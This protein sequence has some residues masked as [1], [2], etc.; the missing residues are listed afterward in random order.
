MKM[1]II[2]MMMLISTSISFLKTPMSMGVMLLMQTMLST[3]ILAKMMSSSWMSMIIFLMLIGGLLILF[4]YMSSIAS[5]EKFK[6]NISM[7][8]MLLSIA[9]PLEEMM[10][11]IQLNDTQENLMGI[12]TF[13]LTKIYNM[14]T[15]MITIMMFLYLLLA[16]IA[17]TKII[18]IY[19]G[20]L[21][22][23]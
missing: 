22:S 5:N 3:I 7:M 12:E 11:T 13:T 17:V 14:K 16:M 4:M 2:K 6:P 8:I 19:K 1:L 15:M 23:K 21:R 10:S 20:P 9:I 18:K